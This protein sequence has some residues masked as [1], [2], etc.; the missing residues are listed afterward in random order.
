MILHLFNYAKSWEATG[1]SYYWPDCD[2]IQICK[3]FKR[4]PV[5]SEHYSRFTEDELYTHTG[6]SRLSA[7]HH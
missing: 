6:I 4:G 5:G 2:M 1:G 3:L 7:V